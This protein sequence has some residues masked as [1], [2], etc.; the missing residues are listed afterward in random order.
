M[1]LPLADWGQRGWRL[2]YVLPLVSLVLVPGIARR[3]PESRRFEAPHAPARFRG[4]RNRLLLLATAG[5]L[6]NLFVAPASSFQNRYLR[7]QRGFSARRISLFTLT[8]STPGGVGVVVGGRLADVRGRKL[9]GAVAVAVG[10]VCTATG[11][12]VGGWP[13][14]LVA[15]SGSIVGAA[16]IPSLGVYGAEQFP[17]GLRARAGGVGTAATLTGSANGQVLVGAVVDRTG[18]FGPVLAALAVGPVLVALLVLGCFPET[19]QREL[20]ELNPEDAAVGVAGAVGEASARPA[21]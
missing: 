9:V 7:E 2:V 5:L 18:R 10:A 12:L 1:A 21:S 14:W 6:T 8:T 11:F 16:A 15:A 20:E 13:L 19:A 3:L 17:T 4:H